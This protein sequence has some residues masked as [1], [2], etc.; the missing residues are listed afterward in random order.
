V[1]KLSRLTTPAA[2]RKQGAEKILRQLSAKRATFLAAPCLNRKYNRVRLARFGGS[3]AILRSINVQKS[4]SAHSSRTSLWVALFS[5]VVCFCICPGVAQAFPQFLP[6]VKKTY[7]VKAGGAIDAKR[8]G[9]CHADPA[10]GGAVNPYGKEVKTFLKLAATNTLTPELLHSMDTKDPDGDGFA[11]I[12]EFKADTLPGDATSHS[13]KRPVLDVKPVFVEGELSPF[14]LKVA[15]FAKNAQ[16]PVLVHFPIALYLI[17]LLFDV[18]GIWKKNEGMRVTARYNL[19]AAAFGGLFAVITG[20]IAWQWQ[21]GGAELKGNLQLHLILGIV[22]TGLLFVLWTLRTLLGKKP[23][24][25]LSRLYF[26][27][28]LIALLLISLT[29]H[30]GGILSGVVQ[31]AQ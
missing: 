5:G 12:D 21:Y 28:S 7:A 15:L 26:V 29:G 18:L 27:L 19:I 3:S 30:I 4:I 8:C 31:G 25:A 6:I 13:A 20:L 17:S 22:T 2:R 23:T 11:N 14:D 10:G 24:V 16:H 9:V 1:S